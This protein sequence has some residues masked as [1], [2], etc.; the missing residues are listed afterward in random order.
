MR[1]VVKAGGSLLDKEETVREIVKDVVELSKKN[2]II[3][4]HGWGRQLNRLADKYGVKQ[5]WVGKPRPWRVTDKETLE[6]VRN[7]VC[8]EVNGHLCYL[9]DKFGGKAVGLNGNMSK[10]ILA[11]ELE[12]IAWE[13]NGEEKEEYIGFTGL[14]KQVNVELLELLLRDGFIPVLASLAQGVKFECLNINGDELAGVAAAQLQADAMILLTDVKG[15][16]EDAKNE[17]SLVKEL[18]AKKI[19]EMLE[20]KKLEGGMVEKAKAC[21]FAKQAKVSLVVMADGRIK[22]PASEALKGK[23]TIITE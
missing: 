18:S 17:K 3:F 16:L 9:I 23:G 2:E 11:E 15:F 14:T 21:A 19:L 20:A 8:G 5:R 22:K 4:V 12:Y 13:D 10:A 1:I 7:L 6:L